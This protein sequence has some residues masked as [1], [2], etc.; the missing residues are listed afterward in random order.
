MQRY[1]VR[2]NGLW[3]ITQSFLPQICI[4]LEAMLLKLHVKLAPAWALIWVNF[5][6]TQ[7]IRAKAGSGHF[8]CI[9]VYCLHFTLWLCQYKSASPGRL[10]FLCFPYYIPSHGTIILHNMRISHH[11]MWTYA[12][13]TVPSSLWQTDVLFL[14]FW[15]VVDVLSNIDL[16]AIFLSWQLWT[17]AVWVIQPM[18]VLITLLEQHSDRMPPTVVTRATTWWETALA[19]VKLQEIG[20]GVHLPV[21]VCY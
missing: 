2:S 21:K 6:P 5:D 12:H 4:A 11:F 15:T 16:H 18:A 10:P 8:L 9:I 19:L 14:F 17:V 1:L 3:N 7:E 13:T 20:L